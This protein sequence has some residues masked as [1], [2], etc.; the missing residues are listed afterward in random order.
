[1]LANFSGFTLDPLLGLVALCHSFAMVRCYSWMALL[2]VIAGVPLLDA[3][4]G[5]YGWMPSGVLRCISF[6]LMRDEKWVDYHERIVVQVW[7]TKQGVFRRK[8]P[9]DVRDDP[10]RGQP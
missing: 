7:H 8:L 9:P 4:M 5:C 6:A 10:M 2:G 1:M 3:I